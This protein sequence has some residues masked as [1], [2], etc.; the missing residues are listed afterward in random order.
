M[1][2]KSELKLSALQLNSVTGNV[3]A[4]IEKVKK[5]VTE[6]LER[7]TDIL[8]L[9]EVWTVGWACDEFAKVHKI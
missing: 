7:D 9:P 6:N 4:N 2:I 5:L 8:V 1:D 3:Q